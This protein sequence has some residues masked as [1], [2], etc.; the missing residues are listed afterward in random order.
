[1]QISNLA[2]IDSLARYKIPEMIPAGGRMSFEEIGQKTGLETN[3]IRRFLRSAMAMHI[4]EEPEPGM[5]AHTSISK[6]LV[7]P[8]INGWAEF[9]GRDT[10]PAS[11]RIVDALQKWPNSQQ[12]NETASVFPSSFLVS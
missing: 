4:L 10:W 9:E 5:V 1:L 7:N 8:A 3:V 2:I 11:T 12:P 6:F